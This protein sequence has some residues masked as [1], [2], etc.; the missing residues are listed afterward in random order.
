ME[1]APRAFAATAVA[2]GSAVGVAV[3]AASVQRLVADGVTRL[4]DAVALAVLSLGLVLLLWYLAT[5]VVAITCLA[6]RAVGGIWVAGESRL[7]RAGAPLARRLLG[8]GAGAA[9]AAAAVIAPAAAVTGPTPTQISD[10]LGWGADDDGGEGSRPDRDTGTAGQ[11][12]EVTPADGPTP[13]P[14]PGG[15]DRPGA[16]TAVAQPVGTTSHAAETTYTVESGDSLWEIAAGHLPASAGPTDVAAA[17]PHWYELNLDVIGSDPDLIHPGQVL[18]A[19]D[20]HP[21][22]DA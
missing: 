3:L 12:S 18:V 1:I 8:A 2:F 7:V 15:T 4:D 6:R 21:E 10:D 5:A 16:G 19:P 14:S 9:M 17:W 20:H 22:E 11:S 13:V